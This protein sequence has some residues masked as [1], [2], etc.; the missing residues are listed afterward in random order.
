MAFEKELGGEAALKVL[1]PFLSMDVGGVRR[2]KWPFKIF[3]AD[4]DAAVD[5]INRYASLFLE[6]N[7]LEVLGR[8]R[9]REKWE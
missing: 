3:P 7:S 6:D 5:P 9:E 1:T 4:A 2:L 8:E